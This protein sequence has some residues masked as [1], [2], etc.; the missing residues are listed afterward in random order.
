MEL[1]TP[2]V[3]AVRNLITELVADLHFERERDMGHM[4]GDPSL[5]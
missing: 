5:K 4:K 1:K 3:T 2:Q